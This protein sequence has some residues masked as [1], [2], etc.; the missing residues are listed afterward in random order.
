MFHLKK[1]SDYKFD[2]LILLIL[3]NTN[4]EIKQKIPKWQLFSPK[5]NKKERHSQ[6]SFSLHENVSRNALFSI[7]LFRLNKYRFIS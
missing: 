6:I 7:D 4:Y 3:L 2:L 1:S 5:S